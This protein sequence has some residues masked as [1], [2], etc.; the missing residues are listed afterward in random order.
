MKPDIDIHEN[1][2]RLHLATNRL[3]NTTFVGNYRSVFLGRG[4]EFE[5]YRQYNSSDD[6]TL[7]DWKASLRSKELLVKEFVE[8]RN[9]N[10]FFLI[11]VSNSMLIGSLDKL[12]IE[13]AA[14]L[15]ATLSYAVSYSGDSIG[16]GL[17]TDKMVLAVPPKLGK[18]Q[19]Y[20]FIKSLV[21]P[22]YY[23]GGYNLNEI[24]KLTL[25]LLNEFSVVIII[26]DFI[27]LAGEWKRSLRVLAQKFDV[28]GVMVRD[29]IDKELPQYDGNVILGDVYSDAKAIVNP[30]AIA[31]EYK[32]A[33][34]QQEEELLEAFTSSGADFIGLSTDVSFMAQLVNLFE[35]RT[36]RIR[37]R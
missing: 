8:E 1:I 36:K 7:I 4:L 10:V 20:R 32:H 17:F 9:I 23:G 14:E 35:R 34:H 11:D 13:Y 21:D 25:A 24:L 3:V 33:V 26:S 27:G 18:K 15:A 5:E 12:K 6:S 29:P 28:I 22:R 37:R 2:K 30:Q 16:F 31:Q 19:H